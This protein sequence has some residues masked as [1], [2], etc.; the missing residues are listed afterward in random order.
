[1]NKPID[2]KRALG[3]ES[4]SHYNPFKDYPD[5]ILPYKFLKEKEDK[6]DSTKNKQEVKPQSD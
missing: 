5:E 4:T 1:M 6:D 2:F 3:E